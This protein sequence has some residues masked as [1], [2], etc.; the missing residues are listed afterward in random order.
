MAQGQ[1]AYD[2]NDVHDHCI[3]YGFQYPHDGDF[4]HVLAGTEQPGS[5]YW[6]KKMGQQ[7]EAGGLSV[8][9]E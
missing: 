6:R 8:Y 3:I 5:T 1:Y 2:K 7:I 9:S 4:K